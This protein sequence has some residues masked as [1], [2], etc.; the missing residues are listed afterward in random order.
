MAYKEP[1]F[2]PTG[3]NQIFGGWNDGMGGKSTKKTTPPK[4]KTT[5]VKSSPKKK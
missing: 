4:K 3:I 5:N 1:K 2:S